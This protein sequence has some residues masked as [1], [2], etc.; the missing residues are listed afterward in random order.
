MSDI[1]ST[2]PGSDF[3]RSLLDAGKSEQPPAGAT[4]RL[5]QEVAG[6]GA[7]T[8]SAAAG[9]FVAKGAWTAA[10]I[11]ALAAATGAVALTH[12][13][14]TSHVRAVDDPPAAA[15]AIAPPKLAAAPTPPQPAAVSRP[16]MRTAT[17]CERVDLSDSPPTVCSTG[18][19]LVALELVNTCA[20]DVDV[21]WVDFKCRESFVARVMPGQQFDHTTYDTHPWRVRDHATHRLIK[22]WVGPTRSDP[23]KD[24]IELPDI[25]IRDGVF[26]PDSTPTV[27]SRPSDVAKL[28]FVNQRTEGVSI[29]FW[30]DSDC[31]EQLATRIEPGEMW[32]AERT[33][34]AHPFRVRDENGRLLVDYLPQG[35]D[36]TVYVSLP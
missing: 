11:G 29:V 20:D 9:G 21:F 34:D 5:L 13:A 32:T 28:R 22:E 33:F 8:A 18:G 12:Q 25:V 24:P 15:V 3:A 27:C 17:E 30:V 6:T 10:A 4:T 16:A 31:H 2:D 14:P 26:A 1:H 7:A 19:H 36:R 23:P 35:A